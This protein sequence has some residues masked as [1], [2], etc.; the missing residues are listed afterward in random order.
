MTRP[1]VLL[2]LL[3][4]LAFP[5]PPWL[6]P[7]PIAG[8]ALAAASELFISEYIEGS[9]NNKALEIYNDTG[10]AVNLA[11]SGYD[12]QMYFNG[13]AAPGLTI[14]LSGVVANGDVFVLAHASASAAILA[15]ADQTSSASWYNGDDAVVLRK[16][17]VIIDVIGQ[18]GFDPGTEWGSGLTSTQDNTLRRKS[19]IC[20]GDLIP[21]DAFDPALEW[22]GY[23][24]DTFDGL[25]SHTAVCPSEPQLL[26]NEVDADQDGTDSAEF[27]EL[28]DGGVGNSVLDG[29]VLVLYN[30]N[31]DLSYAAFDLDGWS[32]DANG[33]F[34]LCGDNANVPNCDLDVSP[35]ANLLQNGADAVALYTGNAADF[36]D[37]TPV[38]TANLLDA[39]V[40]DTGDPDDP[41]LLVLLNPG[42]PQVN[43]NGRGNAP[44]HSNQR[45]PNGAGR[46]RNTTAYNQYSPTA[47]AANTCGAAGPFGACGDP[48]VPI[49][50]IQGGA[51]TTP[52]DGDVLVIEGVV[53]GD[54]QDPT[55]GLGGFF[56]QEEDLQADADPLTSEGIFV[57]TSTAPVNLG[58]LVRLQGE[59]DEFYNL[60]E[61]KNIVNL[62]V[63]S[64]ANPLPTPALVTLPLA[65][66]ADWER[67][68]GMAVTITQTLVA[69]DT[70]TLGRYGEVE[71]ALEERL[72]APTDVVSPGAPALA[73][74]ASNDRRRI[75]LDDGS[76][77]SYPAPLPPYIAADGTL[78]LGDSI[79]GIS[80]VL[81]YSF[82]SY[83]IHPTAP[84]TFTRQNARPA[85]PTPLIGDL[86]VA[87]ANLLNY[88]TTL[89]S[90]GAICGPSGNLQ[91]RGADTPAEFIRQR[92][93]L[94]SELAA[95]NADVFGL[96]E[97]ENNPSAAIADLV[98][99]LNS[100][101]GAGTY[102]YIDTGYIGTDAI[103]VAL[104]YKPARLT[105]V[106]SYA[107][108]DSSVN[109]LFLDTKNRPSLA[110]TF[111]D[112]NGEKFTVVVNHFKSKGSP[113]N[114][115]GDPDLGDGQGNCNLTRTNAA[116]A[117]LAWLASDPTASGDPDVLIIGD[118]NAYSMEDP[119]TALRNG[120]YTDLA[121]AFLPNDSYSYVFDGQLGALD[122]ALAS[123]SLLPQISGFTVWHN[124]ADEPTALD[125][126]DYN[127]SALYH[128]DPYRASDHDPLV[129]SFT[130]GMAHRLRLPLVQR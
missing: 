60:T 126:Q 97:V 75:Q 106:G 13:N 2:I 54:F 128:P 57:Y 107:I 114:D 77:R 30:G 130:P 8:I 36:P 58:D 100:V 56:V 17:G 32:T 16:N 37:G 65:S 84:V 111:A 98:D 22:D 123:P 108:L 21:S 1:L 93:K 14:A 73:L 80:G 6:T 71:L 64:S 74:Q 85:A 40:Y 115:V 70:Y 121:Q 101:L 55:N 49:H 10:A 67:W 4:L 105:P 27:I 66:A 31:D 104:I 39:L 92:D 89:T 116:L 20:Q 112:S 120:G 46:A 18:V 118:L 81:S 78:R 7:P 53:V 3:A 23:A 35:N 103:K 5:S 29:L 69:V 119:L 11:A 26:I 24:L 25:G 110:Q 50:V 48:A 102:A 72:H 96:M 125:Y 59:V 94:I 12:V 113:C 19:S 51:S 63:C 124:N 88:F 62:T 68:E 91:C 122:H 33:Y 109:P 129:V 34:V 15:Q 52:Y 99:G 95:I 82:G 42:Q 90:S 117:L 76:N 127:Q 28:Y 41:G 79:P 45:C 47:G 87:S 83:E 61:L 44:A 9:S 86:K 38:T 43:E